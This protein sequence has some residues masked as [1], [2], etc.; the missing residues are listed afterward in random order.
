[1]RNPHVDDV[2]VSDTKP[3]GRPRKNV[4]LTAESFPQFQPPPN[5]DPEPEPD[6]VG[7]ERGPITPVQ[8]S[9]DGWGGLPVQMRS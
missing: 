2:R 7:A 4:A 9:G 8:W 1:L 6:P 3:R 5:L